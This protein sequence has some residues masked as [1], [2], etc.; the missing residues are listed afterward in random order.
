M[1]NN[2]FA[3][4]LVWGLA[5]V[6]L[7]SLTVGCGGAAKGTVSGKVLYKGKPLPGGTVSFVPPE[8][9]GTVVAQIGEDGSYSVSKV[10]VG[11]VTI[12]VE[13]TSVKPKPGPPR[14]RRP[15]EAGGPPKD[16]PAPEGGGSAA[17]PTKTK[18]FVAIPEKYGNPKESPLKYTV[19]KGNQD[20]DVKF[21]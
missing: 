2:Q 21:D 7:L 11:E 14:G 15:K 20:Y 5:A 18:K 19:T 9:K 3:F 8:G 10:P 17:A 16:A 6:G 1:R 13:T 4:R 12:I